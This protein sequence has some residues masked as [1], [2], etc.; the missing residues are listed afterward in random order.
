MTVSPN[1]RYCNRAALQ[2]KD[3]HLLSFQIFATIKQIKTS[4]DVST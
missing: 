2:K 3:E 4:H 1:R